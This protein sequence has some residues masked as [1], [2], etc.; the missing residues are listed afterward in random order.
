MPY[1]PHNVLFKTLNGRGKS[2]PDVG[3]V[4]R[5]LQ[6]IHRDLYMIDHYGRSVVSDDRLDELDRINDT[7]E[8]LFMIDATWVMYERWMEENDFENPQLNEYR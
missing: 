1:Q 2:K 3:E 7:E 6:N 8:A 5:G 4:L